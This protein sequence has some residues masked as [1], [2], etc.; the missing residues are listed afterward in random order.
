MTIGTYEAWEAP[1]DSARAQ[2]Y[3][4]RV[5]ELSEISYA[6]NGD[7]SIA[8]R[9]LG[10]GPE[11]LLMISGFVGNLEILFELPSA[12]RFF[13]RL[14]GFARVIV[15]DKR[16]MGLSDRDGGAYT[17][18]NVTGD[19]LAVL[20]A[21]GSERASLLGASEG[22]PASVMIAA[23]HPDRVES[24]ILY[25]TYARLSASDDFTEGLPVERLRGNWKALSENW[26][27]RSPSR[28]GPPAQPA[29]RRCGSGGVASCAR[30]RARA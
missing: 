8:Y 6:R 2:T 20:D 10:E 24:L 7:V 27:I 22:G 19:A 5:A 4:R 26:A 30:E 21:V 15:F 25:G 12:R 23:T 13:E 11:D 3:T 17:I 18:E 1:L 14:A 16:G 9:T 28:S 29:I